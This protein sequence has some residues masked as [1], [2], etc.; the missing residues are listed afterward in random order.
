MLGDDKN[1]CSLC[2]PYMLGECSEDERSAFADHL[3]S[4]ASCQRELREL[5][6]VWN[7]LPW[8]MDEVEPP[9][10]LKREVMEAIFSDERDSV[11]QKQPS[12]RKRQRSATKLPAVRRKSLGSMI[13][14]AI[15]PLL[16]LSVVYNVVLFRKINSQRTDTA[17]MPAQIATYV[18]LQAEHPDFESARGVACVVR[19][20]DRSTL[21]VY[22]FG[23]PATQG[24]EA[25][26]V[27][28]M[29]DGRRSN[30]GTFRV[31]DNGLGVL[32]VDMR[33][34]ERFDTVGVTLEPDTGGTEPR[35]RKVVGSKP[36]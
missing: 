23:L 35:G 3:R 33:P 27:W 19:Q 12:N 14:A 26:Q 29:R 36:S 24:N 6:R 2:V 10:D 25:Y 15:I 5:R 31:D 30:A 11:S 4:C 13:A 8:G 16:V 1:I 34:E 21:V 7:A 18:P 22:L 20:G 32:T 17:A 28:L 9:E